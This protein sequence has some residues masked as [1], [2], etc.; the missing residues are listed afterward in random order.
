M[1]SETRNWLEIAQQDYDTSLYLFTGAR[2]PYAVYQICQA[3]E[4]LLKASQV[5]F[6][7]Q[8][9]RKTH[10]LVNLAKNS[11]LTF[12]E[13]QYQDLEQLLSHYNRVRYRDIGQAAY[14]TKEKVQPII[15]KAQKMYLWI[16]QTFNNR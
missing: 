5:E 7:T 3:I 8:T 15:N 10:N 16:L 13:K 2:H 14:N 12:S 6:T 11:G 9:P 1:K 4:K